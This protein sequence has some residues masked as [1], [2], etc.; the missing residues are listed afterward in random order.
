MSF[1]STINRAFQ[2]ADTGALA[3]LSTPARPVLSTGHTGNDLVVDIAGRH[4]GHGSSDGKTV[5]IRRGRTGKVSFGTTHVVGVVM[6]K[7][8]QYGSRHTSVGVEDAPVEKLAAQTH[9]VGIYYYSNPS[10]EL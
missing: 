9:D 10:V 5:R 1:V 3:W 7:P 2:E 6:D 8:D 4:H